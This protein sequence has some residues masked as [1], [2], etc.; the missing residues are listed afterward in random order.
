ML[1]WSDKLLDRVEAALD[2]SGW[3]GKTADALLAR[4]LPHD[5]VQAGCTPCGCDDCVHGWGLRCYNWQENFCEPVG[6]PCAD[7]TPC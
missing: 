7:Y 2:G 4:L 3:L 6:G 1:N 5:I